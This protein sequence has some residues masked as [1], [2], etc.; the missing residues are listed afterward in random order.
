MSRRS[1][2]SCRRSLVLSCTLLAALLAAAA[3]TT[4]P[5]GGGAAAAPFYHDPT[6]TSVEFTILNP[7]CG[8][9]AVQYEFFLNGTSLG[10]AV[11][12]DR[13]GDSAPDFTCR[14]DPP[15]Q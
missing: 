12:D 7:F 4:S 1:R 3:G 8:G 10:T 2:P 15:P 6:P 14:C 13:N 5:A 11:G 9:P